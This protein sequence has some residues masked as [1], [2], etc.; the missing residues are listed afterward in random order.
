VVLGSLLCLKR[1]LAPVS[2]SR[3]V[4]AVPLDQWPLYGARPLFGAHGRVSALRAAEASRG[5]RIGGVAISRPRL[6]RDRFP[7]QDVCHPRAHQ[8]P[9]ATGLYST[10]S[11]PFSTR[12]PKGRFGPRDGRIFTEPGPAVLDSGSAR[13]DLV[14][15]H[16]VQLIRFL[17]PPS[18]GSDD[19][20]SRRTREIPARLPRG[21]GSSPGLAR[22]TALPRDHPTAHPTRA[23]S[24][25]AAG[26]TRPE[27]D[28]PRPLSHSAPSRPPVLS[29]LRPPDAGSHRG[30]TDSSI[31][32]A[33]GDPAS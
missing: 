4:A 30:Q 22:T 20:R 2:T 32:P 31:S 9:R 18:L 14:G 28:L 1:P 23:E 27:A 33:L 6:R 3:N 5:V 11:E 10:G 24:F 7:P 26:P 17:G 29:G 19:S 13:P 16:S 12:K 25:L 8:G 21:D 15:S